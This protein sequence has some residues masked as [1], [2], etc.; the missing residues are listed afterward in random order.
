MLEVG[1][2][3][4]LLVVILGMI[5]SVQAS[6]AQINIQSDE[7]NVT[8][9]GDGGINIRQGGQSVRLGPG[10]ITIQQ[11]GHGVRVKSSSVKTRNSRSSVEVKSTGSKVK[12]STVVTKEKAVIALSIEQRVTNLE[13]QAYG[14]KTTG[15]PL[16]GRVEKLEADTLGAVGSGTLTVRVSKLASAL[17]VN[18]GVN[19]TVAV[20]KS[21]AVS[22][23]TPSVQINP[24]QVDISDSDSS[25]SMNA[26][27]GGA[28]M[29]I[30]DTGS[31]TSVRMNSGDGGASM[32]IN[33]TGS[34]TSVRMNAGGGGGAGDIVFDTSGF[35]GTVACNG[36]NV[37]LNASSCNIRFTGTI[38]ALVLNGS[39]NDITCD[40]VRH[41]QVNGSA[42]DVKWSKSANPSVADVGSA[43]T[44][45]SR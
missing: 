24:G 6:H 9:G 36:N 30:N 35:D 29:R 15:V 13:M 45:R 2:K 41:V 21:V 1:M 16:I 37:V 10:G 7:G 4:T 43:N 31:F 5:S 28:S 14:K 26:G 33:G 39:S 17:G 23:G 32:R 25:V 34:G 18:E 40:T 38:N 44:L 11:P 22:G 20:S 12:K 42:N 8:L 27:A 3:T 19:K